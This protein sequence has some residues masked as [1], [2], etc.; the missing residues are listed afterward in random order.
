MQ[1]RRCQ[2]SCLP[3][4]GI[5]GKNRG[6]GKAEHAGVGKKTLDSF[7]GLAELPPVT[8]IKDK[9]DF[10]VSVGNH[11]VQEAFMFDGVIQF[12][13]RSQDERFGVVAKLS[14]QHSGIFRG[15]DTAFAV[16]IEL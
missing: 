4:H 11:F 7:V 10:P 1:K 12:L 15:I 6:A 5:L 14:D 8:F 2:A 3:V 13:N 16:G 9:D